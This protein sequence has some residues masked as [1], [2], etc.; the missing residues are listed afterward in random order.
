MMKS[1]INKKIKIINKLKSNVSCPKKLNIEWEHILIH[2]IQ[3][4]SHSLLII[5]MLIGNLIIL[6]SIK[7]LPIKTIW[8][9][10]V[11]PSS[12][13]LFMINQE[14]ISSLKK[15]PWLIL[16]VDLVVCYLDYHLSSHKILF[17]DFKS[18]TNLLIMLGKKL[19]VIDT[20]IPK[21]T[22]IFLLFVPILWD[23]YVNIF[24]KDH[25]KRFLFVSQIHI[26]KPK[27]TVVVSSIQVT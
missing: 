4:L 7:I 10:I 16:V 5:H 1:N 13:H 23:I 8:K 17:W 19:K 6:L 15:S 21:N 9:F 18:E 27:T 22:I 11:T 20:H 26:L 25:Y 12:I 14:I 24:Q 3:L 2:L